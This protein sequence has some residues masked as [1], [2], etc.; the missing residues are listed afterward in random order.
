ML[1]LKLLC[2]NRCCYKL[3]HHLQ[4]VTHVA[5]VLH[6]IHHQ[7]KHFAVLFQTR[8]IGTGLYIVEY[9]MEKRQIQNRV[10]RVY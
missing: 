7:H 4:E 5:H 10:N 9:V 6:F 2:S 8:L 1:L 3:L